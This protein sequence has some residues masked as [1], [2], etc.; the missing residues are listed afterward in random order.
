MLINVIPDITFQLPLSFK[1]KLAVTIMPCRKY[2]KSSEAHF[3]Q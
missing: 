2:R 1:V 3:C